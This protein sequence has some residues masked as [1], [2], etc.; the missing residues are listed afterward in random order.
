[1]TLHDPDEI[2]IAR[3]GDIS[4]YAAVRE[5]ENALYHV[6][7]RYSLAMGTGLAR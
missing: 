2:Y 7:G 3:M 6:E 4:I 5:G 1:M